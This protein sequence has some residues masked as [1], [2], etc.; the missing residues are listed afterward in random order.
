M[1]TEENNN[2]N[3]P[4]TPPTSAL[5]AEPTTIGEFLRQKR[6]EKNLGLKV[7][8]QQTKIH[9][10]L[11]ENIESNQLDKLPSKAYV[12]GFV[13]STSK[14]LGVDPDEACLLLDKTYYNYEN[15]QQP[16]KKMVVETPE[17]TTSGPIPTR[18]SSSEN[19][20]NLKLPMIIGGGI[21]AA[22]A[23]FFLATGDKA[24]STETTTKTNAN[25]SA[26]SESS[27]SHAEIPAQ[28]QPVIAPK[29]ETP[30]TPPVTT[31]VKVETKP[32]VKVE[33]K[34]EVKAEAKPEPKV[35]VT[36]SVYKD[37]NLSKMDDGSAQFTDD[38]LE[39]EEYA[40][41]L[42][43]KFRVDILPDT[44]TVFLNAAHGDSWVTY[45]VDDKE[46]KKFTLRQGRTLFMRGKLVR[47]FVGNPDS[48]RIFY[49]NKPVKLI[50]N[51][52]AGV[53]SIVLPES[54]R[55]EFM[56]PLF[57]YGEDGSVITSDEYQKLK[58][59]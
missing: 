25:A 55:A 31:E 28:A 57:I 42:P 39:P 46:I 34:P 12:K 32:E 49:N 47:L 8:S 35:E 52:R 13:R 30:P 15:P 38:K 40:N 17:T 27:V 5:N 51:S 45:K 21:V 1:T 58:R 48:L 29:Q 56:S 16:S 9:I 36:A 43:G 20:Q 19:N 24:P 10:S 37:I 18:L 50:V 14:I 26:I 44:H 11:L 41:L 59:D 3:E 4:T 54:R 33:A 23:I 2:Q 22:I 7:I 6:E 53:K